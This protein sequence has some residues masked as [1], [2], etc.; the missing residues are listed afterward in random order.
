MTIN[1]SYEL[2]GLCAML[3]MQGQGV[4]KGYAIGRAAVMSAAALEVAHYRIGPE[5]VDAECERLQ[6]AMA[7]ARDELQA[8]AATLPEDAPRELGPL[9]TVHSMLLDDPMLLQQTCALIIERHYN[10]EWAL[11]SQGQLLVEQ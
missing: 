5:D 9:L 4:V 7:A 8:M 6:R 11:T 10:A 2:P 3:C 1:T